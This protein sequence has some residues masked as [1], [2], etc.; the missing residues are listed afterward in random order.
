MCMLCRSSLGFSGVWDVLE[1]FRRFK[2]NFLTYQIISLE[3]FEVLKFE[4]SLSR[5][6]VVAFNY[7]PEV[8]TVLSSYFKFSVKF[9]SS[10]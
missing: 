6:F 8:G 9:V 1:N 3:I 10:F 2:N 5:C 4:N 7:C